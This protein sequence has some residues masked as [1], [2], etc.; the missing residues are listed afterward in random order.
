LGE[1]GAIIVVVE[2]GE[3]MH[4]LLVEPEAMEVVEEGVASPGLSL[5]LMLM[6]VGMGGMVATE[7]EVVGQAVF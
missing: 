3:G 4:V 1:L 7:A 2:A 6:Q 5:G